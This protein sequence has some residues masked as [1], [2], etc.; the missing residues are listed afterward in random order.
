MGELKMAAQSND[1]FRKGKLASL[2]RKNTSYYL[3]MLPAMIL[4]LVFCYIP[5]YGILYAFQDFFPGS[6]TWIFDSG[7]E[8]VGLKHFMQFFKSA[9]A[10]RVIGNTIWIFFL[11]LIWGFPAPIISHR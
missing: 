11:R 5:M 2:F 4:A 7:V 1:R 6:P 8:W 3:M 10:G 9:Y